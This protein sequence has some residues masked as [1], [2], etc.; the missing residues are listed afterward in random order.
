MSICDKIM[1]IGNTL[2]DNLNNRGVDCTFGI[3]TGE[4]THQIM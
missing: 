3:G 2:E 4:Q 1:N